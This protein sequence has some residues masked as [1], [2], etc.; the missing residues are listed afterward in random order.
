[1]FYFN[2]APLIREGYKSF[3][4]LPAVLGIFF[5]GTVWFSGYPLF[6]RELFRGFVVGLLDI[7]I[8][9]HGI[10]RAMAYKDEPEKGLALMRRYRWYRIASA[11]SIIVLLLK[12]RVDVTGVCIG[13]LLT[14]IFLIINLIII[15]CRLN[16]KET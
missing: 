11:G 12:Q 9:V 3:I 14:H 13:L 7:I 8:M 1:M 4:L 10:R 2:L 15:A 16:R 6:A 5:A